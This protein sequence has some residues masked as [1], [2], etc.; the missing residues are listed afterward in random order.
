MNLAQALGY[1][2]SVLSAGIPIGRVQTIRC[3]GRCCPDRSAPVFVALGVRGAL[4]LC[5][6]CRAWQGR[7][8]Q[9]ALLKLKRS[10]VGRRD[11]G[12]RTMHDTR[13]IESDLRRA[14]LRMA[15]QLADRMTDEQFIRLCEAT[16]AQWR[17]D[18]RA[19]EATGRVTRVAA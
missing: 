8:A 14:N 13:Q 10:E 15:W 1:Q 7:I 3:E 19:I 2:P 4:A 12:R 6:E 11:E 16:V 9:A 18:R 17:E 5:A